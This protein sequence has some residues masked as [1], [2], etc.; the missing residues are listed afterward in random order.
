MISSFKAGV[1][2]CLIS[3]SSLFAQA[4]G[5]IDN[6]Y[7]VKLLRGG[8]P[9]KVIALPDDKLLVV[10]FISEVDGKSRSGVAR[11]L[12][13]GTVDPTFDPG[14]GASDA[15]VDGAYAQP[16]GKILLCGR[17]QYFNNQSRSRFVRLNQDG[18]I[19][20][21]LAI[22]TGFTLG[23]SSTLVYDAVT[24]S[25]GSLFVG[26]DFSR[27]GA[28][29]RTNLVKLSSTGVL[30]TSFNPVIT[31]G[32][33]Q[34][35]VRS[36]TL[37]SDGKLFITGAF[38]NV[39]GLSRAGVARLNDDGTLDATFDPGSGATFTIGSQ[40]VVVGRQLRD[41][42]YLIGGDFTAYNGTNRNRIARLNAN[43]SLDTNFD[44]GTGFN[45]LVESD[46]LEVLSDGR[47]LVGGG[48]SS[49]NGTTRPSICRLNSNGSLD[50]SF[51]P[52]AGPDGTVY[53][54]TR[55]SDGRIVIGGAFRSVNGL[56]RY[57]LARFSAEG[58][59]DP[60]WQPA[61]MQTGSAT[62]M[63]KQPDGKI[64]VG[65]DFQR[66][67][68]LSRNCLARLN[69]DGS[70]DAT[71][72]DALNGLNNTVTSFVLRPD[73]KVVA[74][75][76][77]TATMGGTVRNR[78][79]LY[80]TNGILDSAFDP[81]AGPSSPPAAAVVQ[82]DNKV[83][84]AGSYTN[85][86]GLSRTNLGRLMPDGSAD[87]TFVAVVNAPISALAVNV[88]GSLCLGGAGL[89]SVNGTNVGRIARVSVD[90]VL[91]TSFA[92]GTMTA[93]AGALTISAMR[94]GSDGKL[95][96]SGNFNSVQ[97]KTRNSFMRL[98]VDGAVDDSF[99]PSLPANFTLVGFVFNT[100]GRI[101][102]AGNGVVGNRVVF[103]LNLDGTLNGVFQ[104]NALLGPINRLALLSNSDILAAT[105][106]GAIINGFERPTLL[107]LFG[108]QR[109]I[110]TLSNLTGGANLFLN[111][112]TGRVYRVQY[113]TNLVD[114]FPLAN[115]LTA[116][117]N[118]SLSDP[119]IGGV[120]RRFYRAV[121]P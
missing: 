74:S 22:G 8:F 98:N 64:L 48:F 76:S 63:L 121:A 36:I 31:G 105:G 45:G 30:D 5:T 4:P 2:G 37:Q 38:T 9:T 93:S 47:L 40:G 113:T 103:R 15:L 112:E 69:A 90:G 20:S 100:E 84:I 17:F 111:G 52:G 83:V 56:V 106:P 54:I 24:A 43:G 94:P 119:S 95:W 18:S 10:G 7:A 96:V 53:S 107:R 118:Q 23:K 79:A 61:V 39:N 60:I 110:L 34:S 19:D 14:A 88:D 57:G 35:Y 78:I 65:G 86:G 50:S 62:T 21:S 59:L 70:P 1:A 67:D 58:E 116:T 11:L 72:G 49:F 68:G 44:P 114:W 85:L 29:S 101:I 77:F 82:A 99:L 71:F 120:D 117:T 13:D 51:D 6:S 89:S 16:D 91:D 46:S 3:V 73:G 108:I 97:A 81:G 26:G 12:S 75:G 115:V 32:N 28:I 80:G 109:P 92:S 87:S 41:G 66:M 55:P 33:F 27:Y 104:T 102:L 25:D 42:K